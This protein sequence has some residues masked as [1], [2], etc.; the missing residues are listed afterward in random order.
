MYNYGL[1]GNCNISA[2]ISDKA[3]IDWLCLPRPDSDPVFGKILDPQGG[4]FSIHSSDEAELQSHQYYIENTNILVTELHLQNGDAFKITDFCPRFEQHGRM[5]R[6]LSLFRIIEPIKGTPQIIVKCKPIAGWSKD[7][8]PPVR[9]NSHL[10]FD[11]RG[12]QLRLT[13]NMPLI[14]LCEETSFQL[15]EKLYFA[16]THSSSIEGDLPKTV[17]SFLFQTDQ[18]WRL[19]VKHCSIPSLFQ[20]ETIRSALTLKLH[21]FEDTGAILAALTT[22][23]PEEIGGQRNWDYRYCWLR[24]SYFVLS[25]FH[26]L[27]HFEETEGFIKFLLNIAH[28]HES[29][30]ERLAPVYTLS[31]ELPLPETIH[32]NW[33]GYSN[34][35]P[36]RTKNQAAEHIQNDV[37]GEMILT[38]S[39]IFFDERFYHLRTKEHE[40]L[41]E[42]L[43]H[44]CVKSIGQPDA[45]LWELREGWQEHTFTN[46]MSWAGLER[47]QRIQKLGYLKDLKINLNDECNRAEAALDRAL[48]DGIFRNSPKDTTVDASLSL[49][50]ILNYPKKEAVLKTLDKISEELCVDKETRSF[51]YRYIR[52]DDFG[53]PKSAFVICSFWMAQALGR[54]GQL[55]EAK[56]ILNQALGAANHLGLYSEHYSTID[57][58]QTGNFPQA[59]SHVGLIN[60]AFAVS[61]P[62]S[63]VL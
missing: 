54:S 63:D 30:R 5:F 29:S 2:L 4:A 62:W 52:K 9:G 44:L 50:S 25:A 55:E 18:Y 10:R 12:E 46:L 8:C 58:T 15:T 35:V 1:V 11:I 22:S 49:F 57:K 31:Q 20:R 17:E 3:S 28:K 43:A 24:D 7:P 13:T 61:P 14:Y 42:N 47:L 39:P 34:S 53:N 56:Y 16:L 59:Y 33:A 32:P 21:C 19:W 48:K 38:L 23:L 6:P 40:N 60:S 27:G 26:R 37:Y 51:F 45:G 36:V 41:L